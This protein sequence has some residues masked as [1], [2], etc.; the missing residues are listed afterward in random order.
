MAI[1]YD[2]QVLSAPT[3]QNRI[4][5]N[6]I[7]TG[8]DDHEFI[9]RLVATMKSG[10]VSGPVSRACRSAPFSRADSMRSEGLCATGLT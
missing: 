4:D 3:I 9:D 5:G 1:L 8:I 2:D 7:I 6:G 10:H